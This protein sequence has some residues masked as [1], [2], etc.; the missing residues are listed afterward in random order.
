MLLLLPLTGLNLDRRCDAA[1][2][3]MVV[4]KFRSTPD[5]FKTAHE[6]LIAAAPVDVVPL[7]AS[8]ETGWASATDTSRAV[9]YHRVFWLIFQNLILRIFC[10][11]RSIMKGKISF[12]KWPASWRSRQ[13]SP[14]EKW[15]Q[16]RR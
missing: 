12:F 2:L 5:G 11:L 1:G 10:R 4:S 16:Q 9:A 3:Q 14:A 7:N 6:L 8:R 13:G 15:A